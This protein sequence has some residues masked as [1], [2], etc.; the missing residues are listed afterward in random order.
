MAT[1]A[2]AEHIVRIS[3]REKVLCADLNYCGNRA[4]RGQG[5][6]GSGRDKTAGR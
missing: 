4:Q 6:T 5:F 1:V 3:S 2:G